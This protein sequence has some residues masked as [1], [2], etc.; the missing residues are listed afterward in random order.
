[1]CNAAP[2]GTKID[3]QS[4]RFDH[5]L[6]SD[7]EAFIQLADG[8]V[9]SGSS[10]GS[11]LLWSQDTG[12]IKLEI[13]RRDLS[14]CHKGPIL[15]FVLAEGELITAGADGWI[16][17][18]DVE[19]IE[20][21]EPPT[22]EVD[23]GSVSG[24]P[25]FLLDPINEVEVAP[26]A[27][28]RC[29]RRSKAKASLK[30]EENFWFV[31]DAG[32]GIWHVDL[33]FSLTMK[34]PEKILQCHAGAVNCLVTNP[35]RS[36]L[37]SGGS[38]GRI[39]VYSL[40]R[41]AMIG[42]V[43]YSSGISS[44]LWLPHCMDSSG[45]Q[46]LIGFADGVLRLYYIYAYSIDDNNGSEAN[47][48]HL[49]KAMTITLKLL[50]A[51]KPHRSQIIRI[52]IEPMSQTLVTVS[53]DNVVYVHSLINSNGFYQINPMG[54][55]ETNICI[56]NVAFQKSSVD[57]V[58]MIALANGMI[59]FFNLS[60]APPKGSDSLKLDTSS[61]LVKT[62]NL[63]HLF[64]KQ[65]SLTIEAVF[66]HEDKL[67]C[68]LL[69][70]K[71]TTI[72]GRLSFDTNNYEWE[73]T[74][75]LH[76]QEVSQKMSKVVFIHPDILLIGSRNGSV[77]VL[78]GIESG[79]RENLKCW[80]QIIADPVNGCI[81]DILNMKNFI[82]TAAMDG[83]IFVFQINEE[84]S[85]KLSSLS[86]FE[87]GKEW[88]RLM[89]KTMAGSLLD[90][91][92]YENVHD[93][94]DPNQLCI[95]DMNNK[96]QEENF[97]KE[98][99]EKMLKIQKDV[100][101]LK[102]D[103]KKLLVRND[104]LPREFKI[105]KEKFQM[106]DYTFR[107]IQ[108]NITS[109][110]D[111]IR[112]SFRNETDKACELLNNLKMRYFDPIEFNCIYVKGLKSKQELT[113][114]RLRTLDVNNQ[115]ILCEAEEPSVVIAHETFTPKTPKLFDGYSQKST[116][117]ET[118][119][120]QESTLSSGLTTM[121]RTKVEAR[122]VNEKILKI[123]AK[124]E[125][126]RERK[127][128]RKRE[129]DDLYSRKPK[130]TDEDPTLVEEIQ[131]A[132]ENI[133]DFKRKTSPEYIN[134]MNVKPYLVAMAINETLRSIYQAKKQFNEKVLQLRKEKLDVLESL[135][136]ICKALA[137]VQEYLDPD[138]RL[139][140]PV[141]PSLDLEE[142]IVDPFEID[143]KDVERMKEQIMH[144]EEEGIQL[145]KK[146]LG[147]RRSSRA[148]L[149]GKKLSLSGRKSFSGIQE[150][151]MSKS[152]KKSKHI[153][154]FSSS[155][156]LHRPM[157]LE[158][159]ETEER[160][161]FKINKTHSE[162]DLEGINNTIY[163]HKQLM[164]IEEINSLMNNFDQ[165]VFFMVHE[166]TSLEAKLKYAELSV[167][168]LFEEFQIVNQDQELEATL[169]SNL[170]RQKASLE[171][172]TT[173]LLHVEKQL[174]AKQKNVEN[175]KEQRN[176]IDEIVEKELSDNKHSDFLWSLYNKKPE[177]ML[178]E[179]CY[180][181]IEL[182]LSVTNT[183]LTPEQSGFVIS[184]TDEESFKPPDLDME[185]FKL[186][187]D[188]RNR[189]Y[190]AEVALVAERRLEDTIGRE[191]S[192]LR[193]NQ[194]EWQNTVQ[195]ARSALHN[196][197]LNKQQRINQLDQLIL[198]NKQQ[199]LSLDPERLQGNIKSSDN[200]L[201]FSEESL[202]TLQKRTEELKHEKNLTKKKYKETKTAHEDLVLHCKI[203][204]KDIQAMN[205]KCN[206]EME[207]RFGQNITL[208]TLENLAVNRTLEEMKE[209]S[210]EKE[211]QYWR[212]Q[213][214]KDE[215]I[216]DAKSRLQDKILVN[217]N[218]LQEITQLLRKREK[219]KES[220]KK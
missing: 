220:K 130:E 50:Q 14:P 209:A 129:W 108:E 194:R 109:D 33:S 80:A 185:T 149:V 161:E 146:S 32:G 72:Q 12:H 171:K 112:T 114:F 11:I 75:V 101:N 163:Q 38:D 168:F 216:K 132:R 42:N 24:G 77:Q 176:S 120:A 214:R 127:M 193:R 107:E 39:C 197:I 76:L 123:L 98:M 74:S 52:A 198:V 183:Y 196:F 145:D 93:I 71:G 66:D 186:I 138:D 110:L 177:A 158:E 70:E 207:K 104:V 182:D 118:Q 178:A 65:T 166:K 91:S 215:D 139:P 113:T 187:R 90:I 217:T 67:Q 115:S 10:W 181:D 128:Q 57:P 204:R 131:H 126:K 219:N 137:D 210:R 143:F 184:E 58:L 64:N 119:D 106:T 105:A 47:L 54:Y 152:E 103:F 41:R 121:S 188:L 144:E 96:C 135:E 136:N 213:D 63:L 102:R 165:K 205:Q 218:I 199:I 133:G 175:Y 94:E 189:K 26:G 124:Q 43:K 68:T 25:L 1:V 40:H 87:S 79:L 157:M 191:L 48:I 51:V 211:K 85:T 44:M 174:K 5:K 59:Q 142:H 159:D 31:Q 99:E 9:V 22:T 202:I 89:G 117:G 56:I 140:I 21:A 212:I 160:E 34:R 155:L 125:E 170:E 169:K 7:V 81:S 18:W 49:T 30:D 153:E 151:G 147:S 156:A 35:F 82:I 172:I 148:S 55:F 116:F 195:A 6:L 111:S 173:K 200:L 45:T 37:V 206:L 154:E 36:I 141:I 19:S 16:R 23:I 4:G 46:V 179:N 180:A 73:I 17:V 8:K 83:T 192:T 95:E 190:E 203:L 62:I 86:R 69:T 167:V 97:N 28:L 164:M 2:S 3:K 15:D 29:I 150:G 61:A 100:S 162:I 88:G 201:A 208:E 84:M 20:Q 53:K 27:V 78:S 122:I 134:S 60:Q 13:K 92:K